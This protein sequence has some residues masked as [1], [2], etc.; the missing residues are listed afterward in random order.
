MKFCIS[1]LIACGLLVSTAHI[2]HA[3]PTNPPVISATATADGTEVTITGSVADENKSEVQVFIYGSSATPATVTVNND[4][5]FSTTIEV[6]PFV[7]SLEVM[8]LDEDGLVDYFTI[9]L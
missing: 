3:A 2:A 9:N 1:L 4:G 7:H 6:P 5:S 8:A